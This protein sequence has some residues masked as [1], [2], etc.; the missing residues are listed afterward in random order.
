MPDMLDFK[1]IAAV[2]CGTSLLDQDAVVSAA[3]AAVRS[4]RST[5]ALKIKTIARGLYYGSAEVIMLCMRTV[6]C[7]MAV[8]AVL[9][10][11]CVVFCYVSSLCLFVPYIPL[12]PSGSR[13]F[14]GAGWIPQRQRWNPFCVAN[15]PCVGPFGVG[16]NHDLG[17]TL[18][19]HRP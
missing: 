18:G 14:V 6:R 12:L 2:A 7:V 4:V 13:C 15:I 17:D 19:I 5:F 3:K 1:N 10:S 8:R 9:L 11:L 16:S